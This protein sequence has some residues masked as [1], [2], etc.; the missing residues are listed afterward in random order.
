[1]RRWSLIFV[2]VIVYL[3]CGVEMR[4]S[5]LLYTPTPIPPDPTKRITSSSL[6]LVERWRWSGL[7]FDL[8]VITPQDQIIVASSHRGDQ[9]IIVFDAATGNTIWE[10]EKVSNLKSLHADDKRVYIGSIRYVRAYD[11]ETGKVLW[12]GAK[13]PDFKRGSLNVYS[14]GELL[15][16]YD[17]YDSHLYL[18]DAQTGQTIEDIHRSLLFF[19]ED[20]IYFSGICGTPKMNCLNATDVTSG[21]SLWSISFN[22]SVYRW[23]IF[24]DDTMLINGGGQIFA[25]NSRTGDITWQSSETGLVSNIASGGDLLYAIRSDAAIVAFDLN[26]GMRV[27]MIEMS[28]RQAPPTNSRGYTTFYTIAASDRFVAVYYGNSQELIV[29]EK[30]NNMN[31]NN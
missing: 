1:M 12:E 18:L 17:S 3:G 8:M 10:S 24:M 25:I 5:I 9:K 30:T 4:P 28:P 22:G 16:V 15:E 26:T 27:G 7:T 20:D 13:Q 14:K 2:V 29:F 31:G 11:L 19:R 6:P 21:E 23:P